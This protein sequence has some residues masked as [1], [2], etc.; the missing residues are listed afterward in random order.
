MLPA[1]EVV[2]QALQKV[3]LPQP[4]R[5]HRIRTGQVRTFELEL[6]NPDEHGDQRVWLRLPLPQV[7]VP[8]LAMEHAILGHLRA[9]ETRNTIA[10][11]YTLVRVDRGITVAL[12]PRPEGVPAMQHIGDGQRDTALGEAVGRWLA[13]VPAIR[14]QHATTSDGRQF[15]AEFASWPEA[16]EAELRRVRARL[17]RYG[18]GLGELEDA[19]AHRVLA[20]LPALQAVDR[21]GPV[22][23]DF[24][25][26]RVWLD[27]TSS[28]DAGSPGEPEVSA[29][30]DWERAWIGD[31][32][33]GWAW[34]CLQPVEVL[35]P[36]LRGAGADLR[37][38]GDR[39]EVY[40]ALE[41]L[42]RLES[43]ILGADTHAGIAAFQQ[44]AVEEAGLLE[45]GLDAHLAEAQDA[46]GA[47][48]GW[49]PEPVAHVLRRLLHRFV[50]DGDRLDRSLEHGIASAL[51]ADR[52]PDPSE[53][54]TAWLEVA[55]TIAA[56]LPAFGAPDAPPPG[57]SPVP[58][59][60]SAALTVP[61]PFSTGA[62]TGW[63][64]TEALERVG[65][66]DPAL[67]SAAGRRIRRQASN[68][69]SNHVVGPSASLGETLLGRAAA[70]GSPTADIWEARLAD[71]WDLARTLVLADEASDD[72]T[73]PSQAPDQLPPD[74]IRN[75]PGLAPYVLALRTIPAAALPA[76]GPAI[77]RAIRG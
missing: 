60:L 3:G 41:I 66:V 45:S 19:L 27:S 29:V 58:E 67:L 47:W 64:V 18:W 23:R 63:L 35:G 33:M 21:F 56:T 8:G 9:T 7:G 42:A 15:H 72:E 43:R 75:G 38:V 51:V 34:L 28:E 65:P 11:P 68:D 62:V 53:Q 61:G 49:S 1:A 4:T 30:L 12:L 54:R 76:P 73:A 39:L 69:T 17:A 22:H 26:Q 55:N 48:P 71:E 50:T 24:G 52:L 36:I 46:S 77:L 25:P 40:A 2:R 44:M 31:P 57:D 59:A 32:V 74:T 5:I 37:A 6:D 13:R 16:V 14:A 20:G 10:D 70:N